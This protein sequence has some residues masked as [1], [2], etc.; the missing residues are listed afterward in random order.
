METKWKIF[1]QIH[2]KQLKSKIDKT[3]KLTIDKLLT[4]LNE[5]NHY[6]EKDDITRDKAQI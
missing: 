3:K 4:K 2:W 6:D 5:K 1:I